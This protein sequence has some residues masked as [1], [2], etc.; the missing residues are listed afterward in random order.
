MLINRYFW[1][2]FVSGNAIAFAQINARC[3][4][5]FFVYW[6]SPLMTSSVRLVFNVTTKVIF[7]VIVAFSTP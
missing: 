5:I 6:Y 7:A 4:K 2:W 1:V 3:I